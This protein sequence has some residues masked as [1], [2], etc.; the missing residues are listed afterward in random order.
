M[1]T[2]VKNVDG[3]QVFF[4]KGELDLNNSTE[5]KYRLDRIIEKKP[6]ILGLEMSKLAYIDSTGIGIII[7]AMKQMKEY[8]GRFLLISIP[9]DIN[10]IMKKTNLLPYFEILTSV[11]DLKR[12]KGK[13]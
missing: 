9:P 11:S 7:T 3:I 2:E 6:L 13:K 8:A 5:I 4:L 1:H 10:G 12:L